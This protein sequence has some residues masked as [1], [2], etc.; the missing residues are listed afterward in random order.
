MVLLIYV[1]DIILACNHL[2]DMKSFKASLDSRF[3]LK[4][5]GDLKFFLGLEIARSPTGIS[6]C[7]RPYALQILDDAG[8][9]ACKPLTITM[10]VNLKLSKEEGKCVSDPTVYRRIVVSYYH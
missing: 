5:M 3:K 1:D 6:L 8:L 10:K 9:L 4:D 7:Q 2:M